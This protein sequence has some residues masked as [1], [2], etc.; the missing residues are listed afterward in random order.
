MKVDYVIA[1]AFGKSRRPLYRDPLH[2]KRLPENEVVVYKENPSSDVRKM[3]DAAR[4]APSSYN[5]Q[6]WRFV[7]YKNRIHV[8]SRK[9]PWI[10]KPLDKLKKIDMG[11]MLQHDDI[12][13]NSG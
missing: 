11:I 4:L 10:A 12:A 2:A 9:N 7:V 3:L 5:N 13:K 1:L 8:F 6:P